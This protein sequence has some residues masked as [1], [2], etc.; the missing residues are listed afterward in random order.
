MRRNSRSNHSTVARIYVN[1]SGSVKTSP[2]KQNLASQSF[3]GLCDGLSWHLRHRKDA[4]IL[5]QRERKVND[6]LSSAFQMG[7]LKVLFHQSSRSGEN[8][9]QFNA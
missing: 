4:D 2:L 6:I 1:F 3:S 7:N 8:S 9:L 5:H